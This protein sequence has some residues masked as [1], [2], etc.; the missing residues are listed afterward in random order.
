MFRHPTP[1]DVLKQQPRRRRSRGAGRHRLEWLERRRLR[2]AVI[3]DGWLRVT[4]GTGNDNIVV[5]RQGV[6]Q[7]VASINGQASVF[8]AGDI[9]GRLIVIS[10]SDGNDRI[11]LGEGLEALELRVHLPGGFGNDWIAGA[12]GRDTILGHD[13]NDTLIGNGGDDEI[14]GR[15]GNDSING[16][17]GNDTLAGDVG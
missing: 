16:G 5:S 10:G 14:D 8:D 9:S 4:G 7:V 17:S 6:D 1:P 13:G 12:G 3:N 11:T 15:N 2:D